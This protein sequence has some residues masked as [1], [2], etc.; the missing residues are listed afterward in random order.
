MDLIYYCGH[1]VYSISLISFA[2]MKWNF[3]VRKSFPFIN[4]LISATVVSWILSFF[5]HYTSA[6]SLCIVQIA[7]ALV[8]GLLGSCLGWLLGSFRTPH[9]ILSTS[10]F[11]GTAGCFRPSL[12][13]HSP[14]LLSTTF[15]RSPESSIKH[16]YFLFYFVLLL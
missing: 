6:L 13:F 8:I 4:S 16:F 11:S 2:F 14:T 15:P 1:F 7:P 3:S 10:L 12:Y 9:P 5:M